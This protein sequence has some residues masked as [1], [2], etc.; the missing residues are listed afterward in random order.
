KKGAVKAR[1]DGH[2][3]SPVIGASWR[4]QAAK[5]VAAAFSL[6]ALGAGSA[7]GQVKGSAQA[8][9]SGKWEMAVC[10]DPHAMPLSDRSGEGYENKIAEI[11]ADELGAELRFDWYPQMQ[12]MIDLRFRGGHCDIVMGVPDGAEPL[13]TTI[14]YYPSPYVFVYRTDSGISV[15]SLD[16]PGLAELRIGLQ[17]AGMPP[18]DSLLAR[19]LADSI[20][21]EYGTERYATRDDPQA[22]LVEAVLAGEVD[23]GVSW[24]PP[25]GYYAA[26][27]PGELK[28]VPIEPAIDPMPPF[29][30]LQVPMT[31]GVRRGDEALR[32]RLSAAVVNRWED[33]RSVL[34]S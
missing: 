3:P 4:R 20:V 1:S 11:L 9:D 16:D 14:S 27:Y 6:W 7:Q 22:R 13:L 32:D 25:A 31:M 21:A 33:V 30:N 15:A 23:V 10:A 8:A 12:D 17:N 26:Q 24:G 5:V 34:E 18:H 19:G 28:V 29:T 2:A